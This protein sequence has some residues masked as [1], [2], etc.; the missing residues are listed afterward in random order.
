MKCKEALTA[1][2]GDLDKAVLE[3]RKQGQAGAEKKSQRSVKE[4]MIF[5]YIHGNGKIGVLLKLYT[6]TDFVSKNSEFQELGHD[7][8]MQI[9]ATD[10]KYLDK[11]ADKENALLL[12]E[13][14]KD[15]QITV[16]DLLKDK[17]NKLGENIKIGEFIR[18]EL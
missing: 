3:L 5:S 17:I 1:V 10:P 11:G 2:Q 16:G 8:A 4:G 9:A 18:Y 12:Q 15:P 7:I 6:E 13:F 14:I